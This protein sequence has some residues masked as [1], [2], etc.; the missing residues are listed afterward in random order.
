MS[1]AESSFMGSNHQDHMRLFIQVNPALLDA[2]IVHWAE[3]L[4]TEEFVT[5]VRH[6]HRLVEKHHLLSIED[7]IDVNWNLHIGWR[8]CDAVGPLSSQLSVC[9][10]GFT[11]KTYVK[12]VGE[13]EGPKTI[14]SAVSVYYIWGNAED[15]FSE[16]HPDL[17][18]EPFDHLETAEGMFEHE[19]GTSDWSIEFARQLEIHLRATGQ[20]P[21]KIWP[22]LQN[23][24][25]PLSANSV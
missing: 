13:S 7:E 5:R 20:R 12:R 16:F 17:V 2:N 15:F 8:V 9:E 14:C 19:P 3:I 18:D 23:Q 22:W 1:N 21:L 6:L 11:I 4:V 10:S 24:V 25:S